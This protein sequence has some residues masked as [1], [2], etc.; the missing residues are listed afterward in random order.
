MCEVAVKAVIEAG[1]DGPLLQ[2]PSQRRPREP[3]DG[4]QT[5][6]NMP[7]TRIIKNADFNGSPLQTPLKAFQG[8]PAN[9]PNWMFLWTSGTSLACPG[10]FW[11]I[12]VVTI[13]AGAMA[14]LT[15]T[16]TK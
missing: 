12:F 3:D 7:R 6:P 4:E 13:A 2:T 5:I 14:L 8:Q 1:S 11:V 15:S 10:G 16:Q 9:G